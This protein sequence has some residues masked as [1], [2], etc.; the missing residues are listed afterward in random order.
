MI[1]RITDGALGLDLW[2]QRRLGRPYRAILSVGLTIEIVR[3]LAELPDHLRE[4]QTL[5]GAAALVAMNL[6]LLINQLGEMS[7]RREARHARRSGA[8]QA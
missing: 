2:L 6:A 7:L 1:R 4:A 8:D 5:I 3:R